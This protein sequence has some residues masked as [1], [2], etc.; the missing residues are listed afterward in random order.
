MVLLHSIYPISP[1][2]RSHK[3]TRKIYSCQCRIEYRVTFLPI[4]FV[5]AS[6]LGWIRASRIL[7][8]YFFSISFDY[9]SRSHHHLSL[10]N[11]IDALFFNHLHICITRYCCWSPR[12]FSFLI[13]FFYSFLDADNSHLASLIHWNSHTH[14]NLHLHLQIQMSRSDLIKSFF[15]F[16]ACPF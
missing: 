6:F 3:P 12:C 9:M 11:I 2:H 14:L 13:F 16:L 4:I 1:S 8:I 10:N 15:S 5:S 7:T